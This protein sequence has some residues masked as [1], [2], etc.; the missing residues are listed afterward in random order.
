[1][2]PLVQVLRYLLEAFHPVR[3][4]VELE[5]GVLVALLNKASLKAGA[6]EMCMFVCDAGV[7]CVLN[8]P[9]SGGIYS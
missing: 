7:L 3:K 6:M 1:M 5:E 8:S 2:L 9:S 4:E